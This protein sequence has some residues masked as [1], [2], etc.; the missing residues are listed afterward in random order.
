MQP[1]HPRQLIEFDIGYSKAASWSIIFRL[2][3]T[4]PEQIPSEHLDGVHLSY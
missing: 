4:A 3:A 2:Q 1:L